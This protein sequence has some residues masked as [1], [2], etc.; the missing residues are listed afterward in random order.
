MCGRMQ[1]EPPPLF[2]NRGGG[3]SCVLPFSGLFI[4]FNVLLTTNDK[5]SGVRGQVGGELTTGLSGVHQMRSND[6][7][8]RQFWLIK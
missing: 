3:T 6:V 2:A 4:R 8:R 7:S 1:G 5:M